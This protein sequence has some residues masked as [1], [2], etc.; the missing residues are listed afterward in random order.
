[1]SNDRREEVISL[2]YEAALDGARWGEALVGIADLT[3][4]QQVLLQSYDADGVH[5]AGAAPLTDPYWSALWRE[6]FA[7]PTQWRRR[8]MQFPTGQVYTFDDYIPREHLQV[9]PAYRDWWRPQGMG[10]QSLS[11][12]VLK[13]GTAHAFL[14]V[15]KS[16]RKGFEREDREAFERL[17]DHVVRAV[18]IHRRLRLAELGP[19]STAASPEG[20]VLVDRGARILLADDATRKRLEAAGLIAAAIGHDRIQS[21]DRR[22][23]R[24][25]APEGGAEPGG[26]FEYRN[27]DGT[28]LRI[29]MIP[30]AGDRQAQSH[31]LPIDKP[32]ALLHVARPGDD[33]RARIERLAR[34]HAL[35]PAEAA[36]AIEIARG[37]GRAAAAARLGIRETTVRSHLTAI[38][39]KIDIHRQA[40][41][42]RLVAGD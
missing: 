4:S 25:L 30:V 19:P 3:D 13:E 2:I 27:G 8:R 18:A 29:T 17:L 9:L 24:G 35:T 6:Q 28:V 1:M 26:S 14:Q 21:P 31:W 12:N 40:E 16:V 34:Q 38:F 22:I 42:V 15:H 36:V 5:T 33:Y 11:V 37:D 7:Q 39:D 23:E 10:T 41:L 20:F 32:A